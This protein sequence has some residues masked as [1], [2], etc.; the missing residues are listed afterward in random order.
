MYKIMLADDEGIMIDSL[1]YIIEKEFGDECVVEFAKTGRSVIELAEEFRPDIAIMDIQMPGINGIEAMK[2]IRSFAKGTIFIVMSAYD[3]FDYAKEAIKLGVMEYITKPMER[4]KIVAAIRKAMSLIDS[5]REKRSNELLIKE[6]LE[7]VEP[8]IESGLIYNILLKEQFREDIE[9]YKSIL[10][11]DTDYGFML[12]VVC[13]DSQEGSHM[14]NAVGSSVRISAR[15]KEIRENLK[16]SFDCI[17]GTVMA[18][19][20]AVMIPCKNETEDY[21]ERIELIN[22]AREVARTLRKRTDIFFRIGIGGIKELENLSESYQEALKALVV[23]TGSVAHVDD[24]PIACEYEENYPVNLENSLFSSV[25]KGD[26][27]GAIS[28]ADSFFEWMRDTSYQNLMSVRLKALEFV[29][30][31]ESIAYRNGGQVYVF[32]SRDEYLPQI[33][34]MGDLDQIKQ[35][36]LNKI[37]DACRNVQNKR[38]E[39]ASSLIEQAKAF[40]RN[41][42]SKDISLDE[43]SRQANISPYYFSKIFKEETGENFIEYLTN[44]RIDKAKELLINTEYSMKEICTMCGY[45]DPNYFSRSFKKNVGLSPT[46]YKEGKNVEA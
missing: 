15:Y 1:K 24:L 21:N 2:E 39:R 10:S 42:Y 37:N 17:V 26:T 6:K 33:M 23:S 40:I 22:K 19:K 41:N 7:T 45:A 11:L 8:I 44:I 25:E 5:E 35:W 13:G 32:S 3:K 12:A 28:A 34:D 20:I 38:E 18:N 27:N 36:F 46:E 29:L 4:T 31:A 9:S 16:E 30:R 43:V 14:T